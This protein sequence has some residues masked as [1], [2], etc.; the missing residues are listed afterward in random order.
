MINK[1]M[2]DKSEKVDQKEEQKPVNETGGFYFST[3]IKIFDPETEEVLV[4]Q[5]GDN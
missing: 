4:Q 5:R 2:N 1:E 3:T